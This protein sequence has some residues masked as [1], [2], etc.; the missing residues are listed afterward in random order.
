MAAGGAGGDITFT[1]G[2]E[3]VEDVLEVSGDGGGGERERERQRSQ[4]AR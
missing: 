4:R 3:L 2:V 1:V